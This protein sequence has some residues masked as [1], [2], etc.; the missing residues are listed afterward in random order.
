MEL[1]Q[2]RYFLLVAEE[3]NF[4]RA[5][6]KVHVTQPAIS[7]SIA[8]LEEE[9][10]QPVFERQSRKVTLTDAGKLLQSRARQIITLLED[11]KEEICDDG[12]T[13][14]IRI[15]AIPTIAP[16]FLPQLLRNFREQFSLASVIVLEDTTEQLLKATSDGAVD[17]AILALP[18]DVKYL[19]IEALFEEELLLVLPK[20]HPL[21]QK[22]EIYLSDIEPLPFVMLNEAHC[23]SDNIRSFCQQKSFLPVSIEKTNQLTTVQE[24]VSLNHG[25]SLVPAM[26]RKLD[27]S[28][29]R[30][31]RSF[32]GTRPT[33]EIV[34][35]SN[36][37]RFQS[38]LLKSFK[39]HLINYVSTF[40]K[41]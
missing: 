12:Q 36:P 5:A 3:E 23:L 16:Y 17:L 31:Y 24:L 28:D 1:E 20:E 10:G 33:R 21:C 22:Q 18:L 4:T 2:L 13:G 41:S 7:R 11:T 15:A 8:R 38:K 35:V 9:L 34:M 29:Q 39:T 37:Y 32:A 27:T 30:I 6:E 40:N 25:V 26:A 14:R 19:E